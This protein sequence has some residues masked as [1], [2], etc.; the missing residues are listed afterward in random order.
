L[1]QII[2]HHAGPAAIQSIR[3]EFEAVARAPLA[4]LIEQ[5]YGSD[6]ER[7]FAEH[8]LPSLGGN[9]LSPWLVPQIALSSLCDTIP[10]ET[11]SRGDFYLAHPDAS[12]TVIE[13]DGAQHGEHRQADARRDAALAS[14]GLHVL[15]IPTDEIATGS[16]P[17]LEALRAVITTWPTDNHLTSGDTARALRLCQVGH[18]LQIVLL[19]A[20]RGGWVRWEE[21]HWILHVALPPSL[22]I[23]EPAVPTLR[24]AASDLIELVGRLLELY[25]GATA[26]PTVELR[27]AD[28]ANETQPQLSVSWGGPGEAVNRAIPE[29]VIASTYIACDVAAPL[30]AAHP[31]AVP[32]PPKESVRWFLDYLFRKE[33]FWEGQWETIERTLQGKDSVVLLPT[34]GGK[35]IAFQ[36]AAL[37]LP[38][39]CIVVDPI[40][41][42]IDDQ[43]DN[44]RGVGIDRC[45][46]ITSQIQS[47]EQRERILAQL[48]RG[49]YLFCYVAPERF[50]T[51]PFREALRQFTTL[52]PVNLIAID[53][54]HCVSEWGHD[55]RTAYLNIGRI[56]RSYCSQHDHTPPLLALTGTAS[57]S[58]L[59]DVQRELGISDVEAIIT[60]QTFDRPELQFHIE[61]CLS[62]EK[63]QRLKGI[64]SRVPS[65]FGLDWSTF[66]R[67][68][69]EDT[70]AGL[71]FC[72]HV[73]GAFG[74]QQTAEELQ[75]EIQTPVPYYSGTAP[76]SIPF[77]TWSDTKSRNA[78]GF[79]RN[80]FA[81]MVCTKAFGMGIDKPNVRYTVHIGLPESIEAFYQEAGR[82]GRDRGP[83]HC[84]II[85]SIDDPK[86]AGELL[87]PN[88][89]IE[90]VVRV[91]QE[92]GGDDVSRALYFQCQAFRGTAADLHDI[93]AIVDRLGDLAARREV[94][95]GFDRHPERQ[96][97]ALH[98]LIVIG[99]VADYTLDYSRRE[100]TIQL[101]GASQE[102]VV[103]TLVRY[104][105]TY[106]EALGRSARIEA[107]KH[108]GRE[109]RVFILAIAAQLVQFIY[110]HIELARRHA[111]LE[112]LQACDVSSS[113]EGLRE[114]ILS[115][116]EAHPEYDPLLQRIPTSQSGGLELVAEGA[117]L[118][119]TP[120]DA[121]ELRGAVSR[122]LASYPDVP[123]LLLL[124]GLSEA[125][126]RDG[127]LGLA[128]DSIRAG[129]RYA[130][131]EYRLPPAIRG[132]ALGALLTRVAASNPE[133]ALSLMETSS[134]PD[135]EIEFLR[136]L[137]AACP[138]EVA[139]LP[140]V[141]LS[142]R[143]IGRCRD[144][145][146]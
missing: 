70:T 25:H 82:A 88:T 73:N 38:G 31:V 121:S 75:R 27:P 76:K 146:K 62:S 116:L 99:V 56:T 36:L 142:R 64:L 13:I 24:Q 138:D 6:E 32:Q 45:V 1:E 106:Q 107:A 117:E 41:S 111:L 102:D 114:R 96:E 78:R 33:D 61:R 125:L 50:Q 11:L 139:A 18:Q 42:L 98:R 17:T 53:E 110:N 144:F 59:K 140:A 120:A 118:L 47:A 137:I 86:R 9:G 5:P 7:R 66:F 113:G 34:G 57:R 92:W 93:E 43:I 128:A 46:G 44:L 58:V 51:L 39:C 123:G 37:L 60:P 103:D 15:R 115:Y 22:E 130:V 132:Q 145:R 109:H 124:R 133:P 14:A 8:V 81:L 131:T 30:T 101:S 3:A 95:L 79:K 55:F 94:D 10:P 68:R 65:D 77:S 63:A 71:V 26:R 119:V 127:D 80:A 29:F 143:L 72:P 16:G 135:A 90:D 67:P 35:S 83:A 28:E 105:A 141:E 20:L 100:F 69:G 40:L 84:S 108:V 52:L 91:T 2:L 134:T 122:S 126:A 97:K 112:M 54:A 136:S 129:L 74:I 23:W 85:L 49:H 12:E 48:G 21:P 104:I 19:E 4:P 89:R 87:S